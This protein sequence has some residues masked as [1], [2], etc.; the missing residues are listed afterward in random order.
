MKKLAI[1][2]FASAIAALAV[3]IV[4]PVVVNAANFAGTWVVSGTMDGE[5]ISPKCT[6]KADGDKLSGTCKGPSGLG[7]ADGAGNDD[8]IVWT[9]D[10][11]ATNDLVEDATITF[12]GTLGSDGVIRGQW[13]DSNYS[14]EV[15]TFVAQ[16]VK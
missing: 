6:F 4:S 3:V 12:R 9:W 5:T 16:R 11:I 1:F 15:G 14:D 7:K 10:R 13:K 8:D 2:S